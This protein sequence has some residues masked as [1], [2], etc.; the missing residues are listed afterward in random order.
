MLNRELQ[1]PVLNLYSR[2]DQTSGGGGVVA[3]RISKIGSTVDGSIQRL[4]AV[5]VRDVEARSSTQQQLEH[6][7]ISVGGR[8]QQARRIE[9]IGPRF[10]VESE[11]Q[12]QLDAV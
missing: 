11:I 12:H 10:D 8:V 4:A 2:I 9:V 3:M 6:R 7:D 5:F 1:V